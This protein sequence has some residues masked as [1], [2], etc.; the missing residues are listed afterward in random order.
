M[1]EPSVSVAAVPATALPPSY[2]VTAMPAI[3]PL[4]C[5]QATMPVMLAG[6]HGQ[7]QKFAVPSVSHASVTGTV[8]G[9]HNVVVDVMVILTV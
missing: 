6:R 1:Y 7:T 5:E 3:P 8:S 4:S 9:P 2:A